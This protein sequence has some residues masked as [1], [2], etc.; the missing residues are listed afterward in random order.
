M[1]EINITIPG[2][3]SKR[4][5]TEG[6]LCDKNIVVT[7]EGGGVDDRY[8][9]GYDDGKQAQYDGFWDTYQQN[10]NRKDYVNAFA[11]VGWNDA[12]FKPKYNIAPTT[13]NNIFSQTGI[14]DLVKCLNDAG[15]SFDLSN[16]NGDGY[17]VTSSK[18]L[19]TLP[20]LDCRKATKLTYLLFNCDVLRSVEKI[21]LKSDG[22]QTIG[23]YFLKLLPKLEEIRF[24]GS[25]GNSFEIKDSPLLSVASVQ[26]II[27]HLKDLTG[28]TTQTLTVHGDVGA[29]MTPEQKAGI[30]AKNWTLVY[31]GQLTFTIRMTASHTYAFEDGMTW[32]A[33][34]DSDYNMNGAFKIEYAKVYFNDSSHGWLQVYGVVP[35]D[36]IELGATYGP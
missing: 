27:D 16:W 3:T 6:K 20:L 23:A 19:Q 32:Q 24:D 34:V 33:F 14:T 5:L 26:S 31:N 1:S 36:V 28:E 29:A 11:G 25:I 12:T 15:V 13:A 35:T 22:S 18:H 8:D 30:I 9:E 4:L 7:A 2:G 21:I 10:G 17:V